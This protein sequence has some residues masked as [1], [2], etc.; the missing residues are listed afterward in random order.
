M[1]YYVNQLFTLMKEISFVLSAHKLSRVIGTCSNT[2][3][4]TKAQ[5]FV[6]PASYALKHFLQDHRSAHIYKK[7]IKMWKMLIARSVS[8]SSAA[9]NT[10]KDMRQKYI[11]NNEALLDITGF[12][13]ANIFAFIMAI[14]YLDCPYKVWYIQ[15]NPLHMLSWLI[16]DEGSAKQWTGNVW[17]F[18]GSSQPPSSSSSSVLSQAK[19]VFIPSGQAC[20][21]DPRGRKSKPVLKSS[22]RP[23]I[24]GPDRSWKDNRFKRILCRQILL[25]NLHFQYLKFSRIFKKR[26][27]EPWGHDWYQSLFKSQRFVEFKI[28]WK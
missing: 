12:F 14:L 17:T 10:L 22:D 28:N 20:R 11:S 9:W 1:W 2:K 5:M 16:P 18:Q 15:M 4:Y 27:H 8:S 23:G 19:W 25:L 21:L 26:F 7:S 13:S 6:I 24:R 3:M